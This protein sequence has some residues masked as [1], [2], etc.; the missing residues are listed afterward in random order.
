MNAV[1]SLAVIDTVY[2]PLHFVIFH[3][4]S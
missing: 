1:L 4:I 3:T 2:Q